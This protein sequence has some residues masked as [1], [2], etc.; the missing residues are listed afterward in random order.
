MKRFNKILASACLIIFG[1]CNKY[2][3]PTANFS[4]S[5][6]AQVNAVVDGEIVQLSWEKAENFEPIGYRVEWSSSVAGVVAG[7]TT[8]D[9]S[10][11]ELV[12]ENLAHDITY[13]LSVQ[14][15][16]SEGLSQKKSVTAIPKNDRI[17]V[18]E[19]TA[20]AGNT[21]TKLSWKK[22][23]T[24]KVLGYVIKVNPGNKVIDIDDVLTETY[25]VEDLQ[26]GTEYTFDIAAKYARGLSPS[27]VLKATPGLIAPIISTDTEFI[28]NFES[29]FSYNE[30]YFVHDEV[31]AVSWNFGNGV[32]IN[33]TTAS[34]AFE[35]TGDKNIEV[36]VTYKDGTTE[37]GNIAV[38]VVGPKW[39]ELAL[40]YNGLTGY[41]KV[42]NPVYSPDLKTM[43]IPTSSPNGHLF[44]IDARSGATKWVFNISEVTYGG[45]ALVGPDGTIYQGSDQA[46]YA[47]NPDGTQKWKVSTDGSGALARVRA[48]PALGTNGV[49]YMLSNSYLYALQSNTGAVLWKEAISG[50]IGSAVLAGKD[51]KVYA[52]TNTGITAYNGT[53]GSAIWTATGFNVTESGAMAIHGNRLYATL[54][55]TTGLVAINKSTG[56]IDW[57]SPA[58]NGDAYLPIVDKN[59]DI[60]FTEKNSAANVY[61]I[62]ADGT[63]KWK[64]EI[65]SSLNY[66][67]MVLDDKGIVYTGTNA[68]INGSRKIYGLNSVDGT[69]V[70]TEDVPNNIQGALTI[71]PDKRIYAG[72]IGSNN[73][74]V[75][76]AFPINAGLE[77]N[78]WAIRGGDLQ[79]TNREK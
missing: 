41:V 64:Y 51:G 30:M 75:I 14:A 18:G 70:F 24:D 26:P 23:E 79:G 58:T 59:G 45:G 20:T 36:T 15:K 66:D 12:L 5:Q 62:R 7:D 16:Y 28:A 50:N 32:V 48:F 31:T 76:F 57:F 10:V 25:M 11:K 17:Q 19:F 39:S 55:G 73:I 37:K 77:T 34:Y 43:Y 61:A 3:L 60:Y 8:L 40:S 49:L 1:A 4:L 52:A 35:S 68:A 65:K 69:L 53:T 13:T 47:I 74:G 2:E 27:L 71:G 78:S 22:P 42:S 38:K 6:V 67:G 46:M 33:E 63:L 9:A 54:K 29:T 21:V 56:N 44:A 72:T